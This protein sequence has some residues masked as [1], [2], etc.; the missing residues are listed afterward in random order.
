MD[1]GYWGNGELFITATE[2]IIIVP[3]GTFT[4]RKKGRSRHS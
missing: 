3:A 4:R 1:S 2:D